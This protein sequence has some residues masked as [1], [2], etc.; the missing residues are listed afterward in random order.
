MSR[1]REKE[2]LIELRSEVAKENGQSTY[3]VF[4]DE[5]LEILLDKR[6]KTIDEL[7]QIKGFPK[8]GKRV[9]A[10]GQKLV[11]IFDTRGG[12]GSIL[13]KIENSNFFK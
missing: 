1:E 12:L 8:D 10:Y 3:L 11:N 9:A 7:S 4:N 6:P 13:G 5:E 2:R